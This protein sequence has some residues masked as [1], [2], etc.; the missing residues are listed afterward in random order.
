MTKKERKFFVLGYLPTDDDPQ[1]LSLAVQEQA[2]YVHGQVSQFTTE[3]I[4]NREW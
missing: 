2:D 4:S 1:P 3:D